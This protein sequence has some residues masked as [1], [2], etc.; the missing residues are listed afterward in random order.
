MYGENSYDLPIDLAMSL[1]SNPE[2]LKIFINMSNEEQDN[3]IGKARE[4]KSVR[5]LQLMV[6]NLPRS[7]GTSSPSQK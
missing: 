4:T 5:E 6:D 2:A 1:S 3:L 7:Y